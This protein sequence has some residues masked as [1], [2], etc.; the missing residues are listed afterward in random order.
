M[1]TLQAVAPPDINFNCSRGQAVH[2]VRKGKIVECKLIFN[3]EHLETV[4]PITFNDH[5][6][7]FEAAAKSGKD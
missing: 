6:I 4:H 1:G 2:N 7:D 3:E 5:G